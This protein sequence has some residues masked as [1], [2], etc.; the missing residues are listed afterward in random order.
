MRKLFHAAFIYM[1]VGVASGLFYREFTKL[2]D[3]PEGQFTQLGLVHTHLLTL[4]FIVLLI[5]LILEKVFS[6]SHSKLFAWFFWIYNAG[7]ILTSAM[8]VT[9]GMLTVLG[10]ES[11]KMIAGIAG[12]GHIL[13]TAGMILLFLALRKTLRASNSTPT[14]PAAVEV[15]TA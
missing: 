13:L 10:Q 15:P 3:F 1:V 6:L 9:H 12:L 7:V 11:T 2:N 8:L 4:G 14:V 5:V